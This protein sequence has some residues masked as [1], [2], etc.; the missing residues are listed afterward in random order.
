VN[1][2]DK[3]ICIIS[4]NTKSREDIRILLLQNGFK[5]QEK[6]GNTYWKIYNSASG[7]EKF[8]LL[9]EIDGTECIFHILRLDRAEMHLRKHGKKNQKRECR[10]NNCSD[11]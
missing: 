9:K 8:C 4:I 11:K 5:R 2:F 6:Q 3:L 7:K 1:F 10:N